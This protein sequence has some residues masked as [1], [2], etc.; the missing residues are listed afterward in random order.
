MAGGATATF[1]GNVDANVTLVKIGAGTQTLTN[2]NSAA[3]RA[4]VRAGTL[5]L[6]GKASVGAVNVADGGTLLVT[7]GTQGLVGE[8]FDLWGQPLSRSRVGTGRPLVRRISASI[9]ES[10]PMLS[11]ADAP[12]P[13]AMQRM[14]MAPR[15]GF[16]GVRAQ[17]RPVRAVNTTSDITRGFSSA[18]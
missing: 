10:K 11:A 17:T 4:E 1:G 16:M 18:R 8:F 2:T 15:A 7:Y 13:T 3:G 5:E 9:L 6:F 14:A 12:A